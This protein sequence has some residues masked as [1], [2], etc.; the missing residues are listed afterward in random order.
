MKKYLFILKTEIMSSL[1]YVYNLAFGFLG[2]FFILFVFIN[3]WKYMYSDPNKLINGY[4]M[5]Q[6]IWYVII[7]EI[8]WCV[9]GGRSLCKKICDDVK[10]GNIAYNINKPYSYIGYCLSSHLGSAFIKGIIYIFLGMMTGF[11]FLGVFPNLSLL[12]IIVTLISGILSTIISILLIT[13]IG[14]ISFFVEDANP[15]YW[16]YSKMILVLGTI[17]PIEFFPAVLK[18]FLM[19]SPIY[20]VSYGPAKLF[21]DFNFSDCFLVLFAQI[22]YII[23]AY[24]ICSLLYKKGVKRLNVNG[25]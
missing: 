10:G 14:L 17:F 18:P 12:S 7:T 1:Q 25:G 8:L 24:L 2:Y 22:I 19:L 16:L 6:M 9:L 11:L 20:V 21:V 13:A 3:L 23:L 4:D 15:F 5:N